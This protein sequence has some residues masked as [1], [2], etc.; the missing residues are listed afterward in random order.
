MP[1]EFQKVIDNLLKDFPQADEI[2]D[3]ILVI[4]KGTKWEHIALVEKFFKKLDVSNAALKLRKF[5]FAKN[6]CKWLGFRIGK[7]GITPLVRKTQ[8]KLAEVC[9]PLR[10]L[11]CF[12]N[13]FFWMPACD[14]AFQHLKRLV[15]KIVKIKHY[16]IH[17]GRI[18]CDASHD[19]VGPC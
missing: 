15:K 6:E 12:K 8:A 11:L 14:N 4:S 1:V 3:D 19:A 9:S 5:E 17:R 7:D 16:D 18:V 10:P 2:I 13:E